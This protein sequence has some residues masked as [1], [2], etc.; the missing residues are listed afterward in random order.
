L[1]LVA[2]GNSSSTGKY[3]YINVIIYHRGRTIA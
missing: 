2:T 1:S 3:H